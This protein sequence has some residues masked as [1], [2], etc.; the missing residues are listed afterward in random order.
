MRKFI[1]L[2][3]VLSALAL[4]C[5]ASAATVSGTLTQ[6][7]NHSTRQLEG[8]TITL[9]SKDGSIAQTVTDD[10][11]RYRFTGVNQGEHRIQAQ[12]PSDHVPALKDENNWLLPAQNN[13]AVTDWFMVD[14]NNK[15]HLTPTAVYGNNMDLLT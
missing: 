2:L 7:S 11:G 15:T 1:T 10:N 12:L 9:E 6:I 14:G 8:I 4:P 3:F 5:V 13:K